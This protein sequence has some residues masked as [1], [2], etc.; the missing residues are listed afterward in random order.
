MTDTG[1]QVGASLNALTREFDIISH[2]MANV[3]TAGFKRRCNS[4]TQVLAAQEAEQKQGETDDSQGLFDFSQG[5][6]VQTDRTLDIALHGDGFFVIETPEGPVYTRHGIFSTNQNGQIVDTAGRIVAGVAGPLIMP[7][8]MDTTDLYVTD[9]GRAIAGQTEIGKFRIVEFPGSQDKLWPV[10]QN[11][12]QAPENVTPVDSVETVVK[13]GYQES[14][15]VKLVDE[16]VNMILVS[17]MYEAN[18]RLVSVKKDST[19][20]ALGVAMG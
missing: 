10:G 13:Q 17:R 3:G 12:F 7:P 16:L 9:D 2:N 11:C 5:N 14:S 1:A 18:M 4:F 19:S 15:N 20:A 8:D 6:L